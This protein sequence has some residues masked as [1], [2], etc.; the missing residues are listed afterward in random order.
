[1]ASGPTPQTHFEA[2]GQALI[3]IT[4]PGN[5]IADIKK[6]LTALIMISNRSGNGQLGIIIKVN[7]K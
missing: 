1:M 3:G 2:W 4:N 6:G 7:L 5:V